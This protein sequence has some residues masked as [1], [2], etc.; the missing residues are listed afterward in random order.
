VAPH[1]DLLALPRSVLLALWLRDL[2]DRS[3]APEGVR[4]AVRAIEEDDEP[5]QVVGGPAPGLV[6]LLGH[7]AGT[8]STVVATLPAPGDPAGV[9]AAAATPALDAGECVLVERTDGAWALVPEVEVFGSALEPGHMVTWHMHP[10]PE[11]SVRFLGSLGSPAEAERDLRDALREATGALASLDVARWRPDAAEA[12]ARLRG[13]DIP[14]WAL[15]DGVEQRRLRVL[16]LA[17]RLRG[18]VALATADDGGAVNLWQADQRST[19]LREVDRAARRA[20]SAVT[21]G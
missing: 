7:W 4:R 19:A 10:V 14:V 1:D 11:W 6:D 17:V 21:L 16:S 3:A 2:S 8:R 15:P 20:L 5:H 18:I 9:P 12:I 13:E